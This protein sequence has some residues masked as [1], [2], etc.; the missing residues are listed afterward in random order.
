MELDPRLHA[1]RD[2]LADIALRGRVNALRFVEAELRQ[3]SVSV[4]S[5]HAEP[6]IDSGRVTEAL[7]GEPVNV[8]QVKDGWAF[9]QLVLDSYVG[10]VPARCLTTQVQDPTHRIAVPSTLLY[11]KPDV[12]SNPVQ[13]V[14]MNSLV[15]VI[16]VEGD[17]ARLKDHRFAW[18]KHLMPVDTH[19]D[20]PA[21]VAEAFVNAPYLWGGK[22]FAGLDCSGLVQLAWQACGFDCPRDVDM[23]QA[24]FGVPLERNR[25]LKLA[26]NDLVFWKGHVGMMLDADNLVHANGHHMQAVVEPLAGAIKRI[27]NLYGQVTGVS[28]VPEIHEANDVGHAAQ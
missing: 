14:H 28:R 13:P 1:Y 2:D 23:I 12:K 19:W 27:A 5:V 9:V 15:S 24:G 6:R 10:Y 11:V 3:V 25:D 20:D 18:A 8:F 17:F 22:S 7:M 4:A 21:T 26:R 16:R